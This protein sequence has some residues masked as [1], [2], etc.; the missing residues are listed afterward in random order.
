MRRGERTHDVEDVIR[1][2]Q[3]GVERECVRGG[4]R[5]IGRN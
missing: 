3:E 4:G 1:V 5:A 2:R